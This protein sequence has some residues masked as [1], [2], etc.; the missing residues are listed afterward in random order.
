MTH[1]LERLADAANRRDFGQA[2]DAILRRLSR[3]AP[4][5]AFHLT[6][7]RIRDG[8]PRLLAAHPEDAWAARVLAGE[9]EEPPPEY[10]GPGENHLANAIVRLNAGRAEMHD[11]ER[12]LPHLAAAIC[13]TVASAGWAAYGRKHPKAW[14]AMS[15]R[16]RRHAPM[17]RRLSEFARNYAADSDVREAEMREWEAIIAALRTMPGPPVL[18]GLGDEAGEPSEDEETSESL[19]RL[20]GAVERRR[21]PDAVDALWGILSTGPASFAVRLAEDRIRHGLPRLLANHPADTWA[22]RALAGSAEPPPEYESPGDAVLASAIMRLNEGWSTPRDARDGYELAA[23][24]AATAL[25]AG[26]AE[27]GRK[28]PEEWAWY[29]RAGTAAK[30]KERYQAFLAGYWTDADAYEAE[31]R[32]WDAIMAA[33]TTMRDLGGR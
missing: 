10:E 15:R 14:K 16:A 33:L 29:V 12:S 25:S 3:G 26:W 19:Q 31:K 28:H 24:T 13:S 6:E 2:E 17:G 20:A 23:A 1:S 11:P 7:N 5:F 27:Y 22:A 8:L 32:E 4:A 30:Q 18:S 21:I 9:L